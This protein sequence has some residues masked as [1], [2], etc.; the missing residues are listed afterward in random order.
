MGRAERPRRAG[1]RAPLLPTLVLRHYPQPQLLAVFRASR[2]SIPKR[3]LFFYKCL[4]NLLLPACP[5]FPF[6]LQPMPARLPFS[7]LTPLP[8]LS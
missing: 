1:W 6:I 8:Q 4:K 3:S 7:T 2:T 5:C